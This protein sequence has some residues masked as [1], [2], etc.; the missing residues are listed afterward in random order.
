MV[1]RSRLC[2]CDAVLKVARPLDCWGQRLVGGLCKFMSVASARVELPCFSGGFFIP[3]VSSFVLVC[4]FGLVE[5]A[6]LG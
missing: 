1:L 2:V 4:L 6:L 3:Y 5:L